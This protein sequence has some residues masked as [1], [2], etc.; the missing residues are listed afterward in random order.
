MRFSIVIP[1]YN[2]EEVIAKTLG[3][4]RRLGTPRRDYEIIVVDNNSKDRTGEIARANKADKVIFEREPGTNFAREAGRK[5]AE[6][7]IIAFLDADS[8]PPMDW[9]SRIEADLSE[10]GMAAVSGPFDYG[11]K[12]IMRFVDKAYSK[13]FLPNVPKIL[14]TL[15]WRK[16]GVIIGGN[17]AAWN[18]ALEKIGGLPPLKF[19]GDDVAIAMLLSRHVGKVRFDPEL[20]V[21]SSPRRF[22]KEGLFA[23]NFRY[24]GAY[25][26]IYFSKEFR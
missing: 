9:L 23:T 17:F 6:G 21:K 11:F 26:K 7:E 1:A 4:L 20:S 15:F 22:E 18:W 10:P 14:R 5:A 19:Y 13:H 3:S 24:I 8:T 16:A 2:E 12:G 25:L